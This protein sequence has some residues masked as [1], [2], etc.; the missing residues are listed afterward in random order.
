[1]DKASER[2][3]NLRREQKRDR[4]L[5]AITTNR[6][7][8]RLDERQKYLDRLEENVSQSR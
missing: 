7:Q 5:L 3:A 8:A 4:K 6:I 1:M 2:L